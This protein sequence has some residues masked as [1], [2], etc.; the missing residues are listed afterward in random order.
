MLP[1]LELNPELLEPEELTL[2]A[3]AGFAASLNAH[4]LYNTIHFVVRLSPKIHRLMD[5][6]ATGIYAVGEVDGETIQAFST[7]LH[8]T[9]HW[10]QHIGSTAGLVLSL[11]YP[12]QAHQN[13][14][15][16]KTVLR[17]VGPKKSL[18][19]W[20]EN[21]ARGGMTI[22][23]PELASANHAVN[24][25][26]DVEFY[27]LITLD[28]PATVEFSK[29]PYF[30]S[31]GHCYWMAYHHAVGLLSAT[32]D[33]EL[34][35]LPRSETW[36]EGFLC[37]RESQVEGFVYGGK[38]K[39]APLGLRALFEGQARFLQLQYLT[40]AVREPPTCQELRTKKYFE[41][42]YGE[43]FDAFLKITRAS[44]PE[45]VDDPVIGLFLLVIDLAINPTA[46]FPLD[47]E[48]FENFI[49]DVDPGIRFLRLCQAVRERPNLLS[50]IT[51]YSRDEYMEVANVLA[52]AC[53]YDHPA[54]VLEKVTRWATES[55]GVVKIMEEKETFLYEPTNLVVRV[56]FSHFVSFC[57]DKLRYPEFFCWTGAWM[58]GR[59]AGE[60]SQRL[61]RR[62][63]S[64]YTDKADDESI[65]PRHFPD[66][67]EA[68]LTNTLNIFYQNIVLYDLTRQWILKKG[69]FVYDYAWLS[70]AFSRE[71]M[72]MIDWAEGIF[73]SGYG[74]RPDDFEILQP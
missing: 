40:F 16:L 27:K 58:A 3:P 52:D 36:L 35:H 72:K 32:V 24:N 61:F 26:V 42:I 22:D 46:G 51:D 44:W 33:R 38:V 7:Y 18:M 70:Q 66:K 60:N 74:V 73:H 30:E 55:P 56:L 25:A 57:I 31:V 4:G 2:S 12:A 41:G 39:V 8:E 29:D 67:D 71:K 20:A 49:L 64:L 68:G 19:G 37:A 17:L 62:Y 13:A 5:K 15:H 34:K 14:E 1:H 48:S 43:A 47:I 21:A 59:R 69:A 6:A 54:M 45:K 50:A 53:G 9:M 11:A 23:K 63:L 65:F 28:P 10:W